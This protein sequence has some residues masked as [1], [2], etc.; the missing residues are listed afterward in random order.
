MNPNSCSSSQDPKDPDPCIWTKRVLSCLLQ[1]S[2]SSS[3]IPSV[4]TRAVI[5]LYLSQPSTKIPHSPSDMSM[6]KAGLSGFLEVLL[7]AAGLG[8]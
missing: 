3:L 6:S 2:L 5:L 7:G 1:H 4:S 8:G